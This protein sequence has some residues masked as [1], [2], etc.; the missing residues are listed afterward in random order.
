MPKPWLFLQRAI[1]T[2]VPLAFPVIP[3]TAL[4]SLSGLFTE[5]G[6]MSISQMVS[7]IIE[8]LIFGNIAKLVHIL[9]HLVN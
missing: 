3:I 8:M 9:H 4:N 7:R 1:K 6:L 2:I 5:A